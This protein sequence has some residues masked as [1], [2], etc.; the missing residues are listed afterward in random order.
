MPELV[1]FVVAGLPVA[2]GSKT[3]V[4]AGGYHRAVESNDRNLRPWR[5]AVAAAA[6][7]AMDLA[8]PVTGPLIVTL[9]FRA[10][11]PRSHYGT[12]RNAG[13]VRAGAP[14]AR[15]T[16]PD[17]DKLSRAVLDALAGIVY[18]DD[19]QVVELHA[20]K[21]YGPASAEIR[22]TEWEASPMSDETETTPTDE[23]DTQ[24]EPGR[25]VIQGPEPDVEVEVETDLTDDDEADKPTDEDE[26]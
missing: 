26:A 20:H 10:P 19:S 23:P 4:K 11:R 13:T 25:V 24:A 1:A 8:D 12:G 9:D 18:V 7:E 3:V 14:N 21:R 2:Q 5:A 22:V 16:A 15:T 6:L 17:I